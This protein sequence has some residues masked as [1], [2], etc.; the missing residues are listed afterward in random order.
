MLLSSPRLQLVM[1]DDVSAAA[2]C[3]ARDLT[4]VTLSISGYTDYGGNGD[5]G[6]G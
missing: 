5:T 2:F 1:A 3:V 4:Q 6:S